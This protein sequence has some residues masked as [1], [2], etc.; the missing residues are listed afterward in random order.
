MHAIIRSSAHKHSTQVSERLYTTEPSNTELMNIEKT[1]SKITPESPRQTKKAVRFGNVSFCDN[2]SKNL[3]PCPKRVLSS[4]GNKCRSAMTSSKS[5]GIPRPPSLPQRKV[6]SECFRESI[7]AYT[8]SSKSSGIPK[9]P[10]LPQRKVSG[11]CSRKS[12]IGYTASSKSSGI[13]RPPS[14]PLRKVS[15]EYSI[16]TR[17]TLW[18]PASRTF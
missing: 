14:L 17:S 9:P 6:S 5:S 11:E 13:T 10:S 16:P 1:M 4:V 18:I 3:S 2:T 7:M 8:A 15:S 12:I